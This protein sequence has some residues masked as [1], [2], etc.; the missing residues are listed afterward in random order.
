M[1]ILFLSL[2]R[3]ENMNSRGIYSDLMREFINRGNDVYIASPTERRFGKPTH[4]IEQSHCRILK[5][6]TLNIQKTNV[7]EKGIGTLLLERQFDKAIRKYWGDVRFDLVLYSTPPIT[8]NKVIERVKGRCGCRSYLMLKDIFPQNAVDLGMMKQGGF[9]H[10]MFRKKEERLYEISD[11]IGCMSPA[12]CAY[13]IKHNP[14]VDP[15]KVELCPN[16]IEVTDIPQPTQAERSEL[17]EKFNIP[18][19]KTLFIYGGN[20]GKPQGID[21]LLRVIEA[22]EGRDN[23]YMVVVGSGTEYPKIARWFEEHAPKNAGLLSA[24]PKQEYDSL[25][26]AC[27]VG[28]IFLDPRFSIP[29]F[30]SRLLSY[31]ENRMPVLLA[32]DENT[33]M[34]RIAERE[35]FGLWTENGKIDAFMER[36][37]CMVEDDKR[38]RE[39][40]EKGYR[41]LCENYTVN[42]SYQAIMRH[43]RGDE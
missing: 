1:N 41:F 6:R 20:L 25:V 42:R 14:A 19:D 38:M 28:L 3:I 16:A 37:E 4:L 8:F 27:H 31:L 30:P 18:V 9:L 32:T 29:N 15:A 23:S 22:N 36:V 11:K 40:G 33:D 5:I 10:K 2:S 39:M 26:R 43:F 7:V 35:G 12:N 13:V 34:G 17:L 24:L 21:F